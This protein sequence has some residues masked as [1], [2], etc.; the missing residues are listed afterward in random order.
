ML[1]LSRG[2]VSQI[3]EQRGDPLFAQATAGTAH[4]AQHLLLET[5]ICTPLLHKS[6]KLKGKRKASSN[7]V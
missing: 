7:L 1:G 2:F 6:N 4:T 5:V 3:A